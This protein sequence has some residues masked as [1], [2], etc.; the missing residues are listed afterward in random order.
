MGVNDFP[1][2]LGWQKGSRNTECFTRIYLRLFYFYESSDMKKMI[3]RIVYAGIF[4]TA[5]LILGQKMFMEDRVIDD[6][7]VHT[8][9]GSVNSIIAGSHIRNMSGVEDRVK[10]TGIR[11]TDDF[12][13]D[14]DSFLL[15]VDI[16]PTK[17][18]INSTGAVMATLYTTPEAV[19]RL[20]TVMV[21][22]AM[23]P[24]ILARSVVLLSTRQV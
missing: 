14:D 20:Q 9:S 5:P 24:F 17:T 13:I 3:T 23:I 12:S 2:L 21:V 6:D 4:L 8:H 16:L 7:R 22:T 18:K 1:I 19:K 15:S 10:I 11:G